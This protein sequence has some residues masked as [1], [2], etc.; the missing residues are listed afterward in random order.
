MK[1]ETASKEELRSHFYHMLPVNQVT[2]DREH[3]KAMQKARQDWNKAQETHRGIKNSE[4]VPDKQTIDDWDELSY[5]EFPVKKGTM[6]WHHSG[7]YSNSTGTNLFIWL[8]KFHADHPYSCE[9]NYEE[10]IVDNNYWTMSFTIFAKPEEE[11]EEDLNLGEESS[12]E[13]I[14]V[15]NSIRITAKVYEVEKN[16][17]VENCPKKVFIHFTK[18]EKNGNTALFGQ[19]LRELMK[20]NGGKDNIG[21]SMFVDKTDQ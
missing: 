10:P 16:E 9:D 17:N 13:E 12:G 3:Y 19:T 15:Q 18:T 8:W 4:F 14:E 1:K 20:F 21:M 11:D 5:E 6:S 2:V 7:F